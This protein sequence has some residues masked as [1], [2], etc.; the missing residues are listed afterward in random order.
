MASSKEVVADF[1]P[2]F[3]ETAGEESTELAVSRIHNPPQLT[4][5]HNAGA[6]LTEVLA[7]HALMAEKKVLK[8]PDAQANL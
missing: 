2:E 8:Q 6:E 1:V 4:L 3:S 7:S 5:F